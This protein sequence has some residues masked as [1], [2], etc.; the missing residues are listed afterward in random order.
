MST[1]SGGVVGSGTFVGSTGAFVG[2]GIAGASVGSAAGAH[3]ARIWLRTSS[4]AIRMNFKFFIFFL[5][6]EFIEKGTT[7]Y[8]AL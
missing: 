7:Y 6:Y 8:L 1:G 5:L 4:A 3:A 2:S